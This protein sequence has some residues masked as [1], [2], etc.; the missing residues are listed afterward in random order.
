MDYFLDII[1]TTEWKKAIA[2]AIREYQLK[3]FTLQKVTPLR[4]KQIHN[5]IVNKFYVN[6]NYK[7]GQWN[8]N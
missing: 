4:L 2:K 3:N 5:V 1:K 7:V 8:E 6:K